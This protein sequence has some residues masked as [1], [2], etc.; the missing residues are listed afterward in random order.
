M[1]AKARLGPVAR[2]SVRQ[3]R[4]TQGGA[5][6]KAVEVRLP[7][8]G[9]GV[10]VGVGLQPTPPRDI[11]KLI[12]LLDA[13]A[14]RTFTYTAVCV[15]GRTRPVCVCACGGRLEAKYKIKTPIVAETS[16]I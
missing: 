14:R 15:C 1:Q 7:P 12:N 2:R 9:N 3:M 16:L 4:G 5:L 13:F 10:G 8:I 6:E 11:K